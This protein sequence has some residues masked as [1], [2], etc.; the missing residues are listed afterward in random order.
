MPSAQRRPSAR[1]PARPARTAPPSID[2]AGAK[3]RLAELIG[4]L[5]VAAGYDLEELGLVRMGRRYVLRITVDRDGGVPL[6]A[7]AD[8][9]R[10]ISAAIDDAE[11]S[12]GEVIPGEYQLEVSSPGIDRPLTAPRHWRRNVGRLVKAKIGGHSVIGRVIAA[13]DEGIRFDVDGVVREL[14][15]DELGSGRVEIEFNR[16]DE[17]DE[18]D[19]VAF[20]DGEDED[21]DDDDEDDADDS[22]ADADDWHDGDDATEDVR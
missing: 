21:D 8:L 14:G 1:P 2:L 5:A 19:M 17:V 10:T 9:A 3:K 6:D 20:D 4:P 18:A 11:A 15:Y 16:I 12:G 7:V 22:D 13:D